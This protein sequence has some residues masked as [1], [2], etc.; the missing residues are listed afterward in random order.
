MRSTRYYISLNRKFYDMLKEE[1]KKLGI[2]IS[3]FVNKA[4]NDTL[5]TD[6]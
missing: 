1:A 3:K 2:S 5:R 4:L 6:R